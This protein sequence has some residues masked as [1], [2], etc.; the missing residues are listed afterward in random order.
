MHHQ[1]HPQAVNDADHFHNVK[2]EEMVAMGHTQPSTGQR[3]PNQ[4]PGDRRTAAASDLSSD[5]SAQT[6]G[7]ARIAGHDGP[8]PD[9]RLIRAAETSARQ[10]GLHASIPDPAATGTPQYAA[11]L[12]RWGTGRGIGPD[13]RE[14]EAGA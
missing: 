11:D 14:P 12:A 10:A 3:E 13:G 4:D 6:A 5:W 8:L 2:N 9:W 1:P 7:L